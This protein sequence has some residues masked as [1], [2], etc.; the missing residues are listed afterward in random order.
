MEEVTFGKGELLRVG[1]F[2]LIVVEGFDDLQAM[3]A[4]ISNCRLPVLHTS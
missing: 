2:G 4:E 3:M 1:G